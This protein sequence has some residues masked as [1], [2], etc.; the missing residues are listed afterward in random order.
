MY[1]LPKE[2]APEK[3]EKEPSVA[4]ISH[5]HT[6]CPTLNLTLRPCR[7]ESKHIQIVTLVVLGLAI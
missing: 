1:L 4:V 6:E 7:A 2:D 5:I 3:T